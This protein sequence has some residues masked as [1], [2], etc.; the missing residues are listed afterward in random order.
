MS[1]MSRFLLRTYERVGDSCPSHPS[2]LTEAVNCL[3]DLKVI[4]D[5][6]YGISNRPVSR[7]QMA[8]Y[9]I[10]LWHNLA[11][12]GMPPDPPR[13]RL[14][15]MLPL[16]EG[17]ATQANVV[18]TGRMELPVY[19]CAPAGE[20]RVADLRTAVYELNSNVSPF[21]QSQSSGEVDLR[22]VTGD[23]VSPDL[24]WSSISF[25]TL[26]KGD[27]GCEAEAREQE[28][29]RQLVILVDTRMGSQVTGYA[30]TRFGPAVQPMRKHFW[31]DA[32]YYKTM[33]HEVGHSRFGFC[34]THERYSTNS[35]CPLSSYHNANVYD[36]NDTSVMSYASTTDLRKAFI[37]CA[38]R[39]Q[40]GWPGGPPLSSGQVCPGGQGP[41]DVTVPP[42]PQ[43]IE[44]VPGD[45][46]VVVRWSPPS[47]LWWLNGYTVSFDGGWRGGSGQRTVSDN[48]VIITGLTNGVEYTIRVTADND[49]GSSQPTEAK[50]TPNDETTRTPGLPGDV[51][52]EEGDGEVTVFWSAPAV[53][54]GSP[55]TGYRVSV[56]G[57]SSWSRSV[58]AG[59][60]SARFDGLTNGVAYDVTVNALNSEGV[61]PGRSV[62]A[63]PTRMVSCKPQSGWD[64]TTVG[65]PRPTWAAPSTGTVRIAV[66]FMDFPG[67]RAA[68]STRDEIEHSLPYMEEY[69]E[70][71]ARGQLD[72]QFEVL[73][74]WLRSDEDYQQWGG[75][76]GVEASQRSVDLADNRV[77]FSQVDAVMTVFPSDQFSIATATG[78]VTVDGVTLPTFRMNVRPLETPR[79]VTSNGWAAAH[80]FLHVVGLRDLYPSSRGELPMRSDDQALVAA[81]LGIMGL[82]YIFS[83]PHSDPRLSDHYFLPD[84]YWVDY[85]LWYSEML[86]WSRWQ[87]GWINS[88]EMRCVTEPYATVTLVPIG[89]D[90][91]G[92]LLAAVPVS[93]TRVI[94]ME[95]RSAVGRDENVGV[96]NQG[97]MVYT[98]ETSATSLPIKLVR[99]DA[100]IV[101]HDYPLLQVGESVTVWD[102]DITVVQ[103]DGATHTVRIT[104]TG[105]VTVP[106]VV[107]GLRVEEGDGVLTVFW[108]APAV[109]GG[110][111]VTGYRVWVSGD[112]SWS[113]SVGGGDRSARFDGLTN[114]V[115]YE[116]T[117]SAVNGEGV[118]PGWT[119]V[120]GPIR[121]VTV[122]GAPTVHAVVRGAAIEASW[123]A[124]D[125]GSRI[126]RW[127]ISGVGE[128]GAATVSY[129]W[130]N[131]R[132]DTYHVRVRAHN[133][134]GWG[135][136]GTSN[137]V[138]VEPPDPSVRVSRGDP[139]PTTAP[140]P[141]SI[142]CATEAPDCRWL[143]IELRD[144]PQGRYRVYCVHD[145][146]GQHP[147][148]YWRTFQVTVGTSG[149][150]V[151]TRECYINIAGARG[152]GVIVYVGE[153]SQS[154]GHFKWSSNWLK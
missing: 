69:L 59:A 117:V 92:T 50:A 2:E 4:P 146:W 118:G 60:R 123:S 83:L 145:G 32:S 85:Q 127:E 9:V 100:D 5:R 63:A 102:H 55:V 147:A 75:W 28:G 38:H 153:S 86:G 39:Q 138:T 111:P 110:S 51:R 33:V 12:R 41:T 134:A 57:D 54:G 139:G 129:T 99:D 114:G 116:V 49:R 90:H 96:L 7:A 107:G 15:V 115:L 45:E 80:E 144:F 93:P 53:D 148:G 71:A 98:I 21:F 36:P 112:S 8:V 77:D 16:P 109:D 106:G 91:D 97:V 74:G 64:H 121:A 18:T 10:G 125:N 137:T 120:G 104:P 62:V 82:E 122:P 65:F 79:S 101:E 135:P 113:R 142:P 61:G 84:N 131:Q 3:V 105:A 29:H 56:V 17:L 27:N 48:R 141:G 46:Q 25:D 124:V 14:D 87:L 73:H 76:L 119:V 44:V 128:V 24:M 133:T 78:N 26:W 126:D 81:N 13:P 43:G 52:V 70:Q 34:H 6:E 20:Y 37:S 58:G 149:A 72:L 130:R 108:S 40:A 47:G 30:Y 150:V 35:P 103:G 95:N 154:I 23:I 89:G 66:L 11:G 68:H 132:P 136:W 22:F 1:Q 140:R 88:D 19:I 151:V 31:S 67:R 94:A 152:R 42:S 143:R